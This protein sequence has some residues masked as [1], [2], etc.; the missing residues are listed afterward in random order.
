MKN[1]VCSLTEDS[2]KGF[3]QEWKKKHWES[4]KMKYIKYIYILGLSSDWWTI[5]IFNFY[6][7]NPGF[8]KIKIS[9]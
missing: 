6:I 2:L 8:M 9:Y 1:A 3:I 7:F 5:K 4:K